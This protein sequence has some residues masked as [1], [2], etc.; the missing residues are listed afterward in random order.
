MERKEFKLIVG[1][2][3]E[4]HWSNS[5]RVHEN[6]THYYEDST[7]LFNGDKDV[8]GKDQSAPRDT[9]REL[10]TVHGY[11]VPCTCKIKIL[12]GTKLSIVGFEGSNGV[13]CCASVARVWRNDG[14]G[15]QMVHDQYVLLHGRNVIIS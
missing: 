7:V 1:T 9:T 4:A 11:A 15:W 14:E 5:S 8:D 2:Y 12:N 13:Q 3:H 6:I 10:D